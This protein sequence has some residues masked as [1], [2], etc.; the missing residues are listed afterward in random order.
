MRKPVRFR[1]FWPLLAAFLVLSGCYHARII[2]GQPESDVVYRKRWVS[3]F[4][5]GLVIPD[6][7]DVS[8]VYPHGVARVETRLS[9]MNQLVTILTWG[10]YS[11]MEVRVVCAAPTGQAQVLQRHDGAR[12]VEQAVQ[13]AAET[14]A[15]VYIQQLP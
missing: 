8:S 6:S 4:V 1:F 11:P 14:G 13:Q 2:T 15:P 3:G 5:N 9:F 7:I 10:I 12:L